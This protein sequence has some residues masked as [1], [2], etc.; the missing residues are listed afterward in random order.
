MK[1]KIRTILTLLAA[2]ASLEAS[3]QSDVLDFILS[4]PESDPL[5][6]LVGSVLSPGD[7]AAANVANVSPVSALNYISTAY[8]LQDYTDSGVWDGLT[9]NGAYGYGYSRSWGNVTSGFGYRPKFG[10]VHKGVDIAMEQGVPVVVPLPGTVLRVG[11]EANGYGHFVAVR[12]DD[13][14]ETRYAHLSRPLVT[15]GQR[16]QAGDPVGLSGNSG[17]STGPHLHFETRVAGRAIDPATLFDFTSGQAVYTVLS[18]P[19][20]GAKENKPSPKT[21][22]KQSLAGKKTYI[23]RAGDSIASVAARSG[24]TV[25]RICQLNGLSDNSQLQPGT[26]LRL[27]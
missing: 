19:G 21:T 1:G 22:G 20:V 16:L 3:A 17:N 6:G 12:H 27:R 23:V 25:L 11:F 9:S 10:R 18:A 15:A 14:M 13:G 26:M 7:V 4:Q 24:V 8:M 5:E 2:A